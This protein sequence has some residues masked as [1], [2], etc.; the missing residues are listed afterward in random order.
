MKLFTAK[1]LRGTAAAIAIVFAGTGILGG[2]GKSEALAV[3]PIE[4]TRGTADSLDGMILMDYPGPK[5]Q[6]QYDQG[7]PDFFCDTVA[8]FS[9]YLKPE[10]RRQVRAIFVQDMAKT[11]W[12]N[13]TGHWIDAR[14][15]FY[16]A[17][18]KA[19]GAMGPTLA[20][21]ASESD[22]SAFAARE[23]GKVYRFG[24]ITPDMVVLDGG[25]LKDHMT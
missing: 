4:I 12:N 20:S 25:V 10:Q 7:K 23:G 11:D 8:M 9:I 16:V 5:G 2:C 14:T 24:Q 3:G 17:G 13:P 18:S 19:R 6:I 15:A 21:F 22:A 1:N